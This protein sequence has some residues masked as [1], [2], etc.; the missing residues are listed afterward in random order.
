LSSSSWALAD[1]CACTFG[2]GGAELE[3]S[4]GAGFLS[5]DEQPAA[6]VRMRG[7]RPDRDDFIAFST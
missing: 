5:D 2:G 6:S 7:R 1:A 4:D 3:T